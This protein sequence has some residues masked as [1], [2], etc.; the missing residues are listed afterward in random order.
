MLQNF[1]SRDKTLFCCHRKVFSLSKP[2]WNT[3][4]IIMLDMNS[5]PQS[6]M[7]FY[8]AV[9]CFFYNDLFRFFCCFCVPQLVQ[10]KWLFN[11]SWRS[12]SGTRASSCGNHHSKLFHLFPVQ[13]ISVSQRGKGLLPQRLLQS[14]HFV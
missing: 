4:S 3:G 8:S 14:L 9:I 1:K 11:C 7:P 10:I 2:N 5:S 6:Y 12:D 13:N